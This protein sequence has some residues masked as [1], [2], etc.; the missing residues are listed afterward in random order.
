MRRG[1]E[2][3]GRDVRDQHPPSSTL[4]RVARAYPHRHSGHRKTQVA[5]PLTLWT[6]RD[7]A[8][9]F[10]SFGQNRTDLPDFARRPG[11]RSAQRRKD[12]LL[13]AASSGPIPPVGEST[14]YVRG[15][16]SGRQLWMHFCPHCGTTVYWEAQLR[17]D[18]YGVAIGAFAD[19]SF[20]T[21]TRSVWEENRHDWVM[22]PADI[23]RLSKGTS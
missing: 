16:D 17:P 2:I 5:G 6:D 13:R 21:P 11:L 3:T 23:P 18:M 1:T 8:D 10:A 15:S 19:A 9:H 20:S 14:M 7:I 12:M 4:D 22:P